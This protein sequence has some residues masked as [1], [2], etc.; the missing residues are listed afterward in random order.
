MIS[1]LTSIIL[2]NPQQ[3]LNNQKAP[4]ITSSIITPFMGVFTEELRCQAATRI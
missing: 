4:Q 1:S 2:N 3:F